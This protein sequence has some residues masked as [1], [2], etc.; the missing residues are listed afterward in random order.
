MSESPF[1]HARG[2][3]TEGRR[4]LM[5]RGCARAI[6]G[7]RRARSRP[8]TRRRSGSPRPVMHSTSPTESSGYVILSSSPSMLRACRD[9]HVMAFPHPSGHLPRIRRTGNERPARHGPP[10][11]RKPAICS[12]CLSLHPPTSP[13]PSADHLFSETVADGPDHERSA[14]RRGNRD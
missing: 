10:Q 13:F 14:T 9:I 8:R 1:A 5:P 11:I 4:V 7:S 3:G 6:A 12:P 2:K